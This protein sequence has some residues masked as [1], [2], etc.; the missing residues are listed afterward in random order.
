MPQPNALDFYGYDEQLTDAERALQARVREWVAT[1][2]MPR[3]AECWSAHD[4][5]MDLVPEMGELGCFG[6]TIEGYGCPGLSSRTYGLVMREL[7]RGDSGLRTMASV[8]GALAMN[9]ISFFGT[10]AQREHRLPAMAKGESL[11]CFGLTEPTH[12]SNPGGHVDD[13]DPQW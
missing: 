12:G 7:E 3:V 8:Q 1:R 9:A 5:P 4:F 13:R 6:A 10:E 11:G 2:F